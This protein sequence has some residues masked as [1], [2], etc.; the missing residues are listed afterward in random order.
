MAKKDRIPSRHATDE[1]DELFPE[2][3]K[4]VVLDVSDSINK[5]AW[6]LLGETYTPAPVTEDR[7]GS[8]N[9]PKV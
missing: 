7:D 6:G 8:G 5:G 3:H 4:D 1:A 9:P 2:R